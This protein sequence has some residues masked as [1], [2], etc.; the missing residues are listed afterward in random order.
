L[1]NFAS[2]DRHSAC[3]ISPQAIAIRLAQFRL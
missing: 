3:A 2:S 1:R